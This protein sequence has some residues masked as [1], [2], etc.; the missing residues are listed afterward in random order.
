MTDAM[1]LHAFAVVQAVPTAELDC[2]TSS[3]LLAAMKLAADGSA[4]MTTWA[5]STI[6]GSIAAIVSTSYL[7]PTGQRI[8]LIYLLYLPAWACLGFSIFWGHVLE[9]RHI[10]AHFVPPTQLQKIA[11][12]MSDDYRYQQDF[13]AIGL[14]IFGIWLTCFLFWWVMGNWRTGNGD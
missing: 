10:A 13:L 12:L 1:L 11:E 14:G 7:R 8:R 4:T 9:R 5:L 6:G 2:T 3:P